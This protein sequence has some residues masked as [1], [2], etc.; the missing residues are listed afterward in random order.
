MFT[1][2]LDKAFQSGISSPSLDNQ[3]IDMEED[4]KKKSE[5]AKALVTVAPDCINN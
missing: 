3:Q 5:E 2:V 1:A 4:R